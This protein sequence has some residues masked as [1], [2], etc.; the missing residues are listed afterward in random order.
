[1]GNKLVN[2]PLE[3]ALQ[4][5]EFMAANPKPARLQDISEALDMPASSVNRYLSTLV[6]CKYVKQDAETLR[7]SLTFKLLKLGNMA[8]VHVNIRDVV[9]P[10]LNDLVDATGE[11][12]CLAIEEDFKAVYID[13]ASGPENSLCVMHRIGKEAPLHCTGV[14]KLLLLNYDHDTLER[15]IQEEGLHKLTRNTISSFPQLTR[16]VKSARAV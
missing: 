10:F 8:S 16:N 9:K 2:Q 3:K 1:M 15:F 4:V 6:A 14:G 11:S 12:A 5:I 7:Y 13:V